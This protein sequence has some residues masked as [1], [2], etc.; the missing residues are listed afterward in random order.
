MKNDIS[1]IFF[2]LSMLQ[3]KDVVESKI[4]IENYRF[5]KYQLISFI[6]EY[7]TDEIN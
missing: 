5:L 3:F 7:L 6:D 2:L 4:Q 1:P